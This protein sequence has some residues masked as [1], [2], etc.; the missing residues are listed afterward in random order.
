MNLSGHIKN[1]IYGDLHEV[2]NNRKIIEI[3]L[4]WVEANSILWDH[5]ELSQ[6]IFGFLLA[7]LFAFHIWI[8]SLQSLSFESMGEMFLEVQPLQ[9]Y[10]LN[11]IVLFW[12]KY[13][14]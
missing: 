5:P 1:R 10:Q 8:A 7:H 12:L 13:H 11:P 3:V 4:T 6:V 2:K 9:P 14:E